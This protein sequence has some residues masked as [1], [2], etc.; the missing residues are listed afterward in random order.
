M[1]TI[2]VAFSLLTLATSACTPDDAD[3]PDDFSGFAGDGK[4]D[5][6]ATEIKRLGIYG[7]APLDLDHH[8]REQNF[9][10]K[11]AGGKRY[12]GVPMM[13][14]PGI[15]TFQAE[16]ELGTGV[17]VFFLDDTFRLV[18]WNESLGSVRLQEKI[19]TAGKFWLLVRDEGDGPGDFTLDHGGDVAGRHYPLP[20]DCT[21]AVTPKTAKLGDTLT[22][23]LKPIGEFRECSVLDR[24]SI[25][26]PRPVACGSVWTVKADATGAPYSFLG[27]VVGERVGLCRAKVVVTVR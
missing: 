3:G 15:H 14:A 25:S 9:K 7:D 27:K 16:N 18:D 1:R 2:H 10:G 5:G 19:E 12:V 4:S 6:F 22:F 11:K 20:P 13:L 26:V 17:S 24:A 8:E 23:T 21:L